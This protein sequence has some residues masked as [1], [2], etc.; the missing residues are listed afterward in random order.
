MCSWA[1]HELLDTAIIHTRAPQ[2]PRFPLASR[3]S[4]P[5]HLPVRYRTM[6]TMR[7]HTLA[8][9]LISLLTTNMSSP[10]TPTHHHHAP[11]EPRGP[12]PQ[13]EGHA[14]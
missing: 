1:C 8:V 7:T 10:P 11:T 13:Q 14:R 9:Q 2:V 3:S 4:A 12:P 6:R 5:P